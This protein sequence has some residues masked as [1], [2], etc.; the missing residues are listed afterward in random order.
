VLNLFGI[1]S[2]PRRQPIAS[3]RTRIN[4]SI[5]AVLLIRPSPQMGALD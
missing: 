1:A 2:L 3:D 4:G 5:A